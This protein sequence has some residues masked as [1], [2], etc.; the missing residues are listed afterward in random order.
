MRTRILALLPLLASMAACS[1]GECRHAPGS[2]SAAA[3]CHGGGSSGTREA[4]RIAS[5]G[6]TL[7]AEVPDLTAIDTA[8][9]GFWSEPGFAAEWALPRDGRDER[10][11]Y[12]PFLRLEGESTEGEG[13]SIW[14]GVLVGGYLSDLDDGAVHESVWED[15]FPV[16]GDVPVEV[17]VDVLDHAR[18]STSGVTLA[19]R[20]DARRVAARVDRVDDQTARLVVDAVA[21]DAE[22]RDILVSATFDYR[23]VID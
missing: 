23:V 11:V 6:A 18:T 19:T 20:H 21:P 7:R 16:S 1:G 8:T 14:V 22:G 15:R 17:Y 3:F 12:T 4:P 13:F 5:E 2:W 10:E 9:S